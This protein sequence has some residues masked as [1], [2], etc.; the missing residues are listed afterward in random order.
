M[1]TSRSDVSFNTEAEASDAFN[2]QLIQA[3]TVYDRSPK[4]NKEGV[5]IEQRAVYLLYHEGNGEYYVDLVWREGDTPIS[6]TIIG[7]QRREF[8]PAA[9]HDLFLPLYDPLVSL[10]G[11]DRARE[12][13][14]DQARIEDH[15]RVL[16]VGCGTGTLSAGHD[17]SHGLLAHL[18]HSSHRLKDNSEERILDLM[19]RAGF[20]QARKVKGDSMFF[21]A[22]KT[23]YFEARL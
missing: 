9:G 13:L 7:H 23:S 6:S 5:L 22:L 4:V 11:G 17:G 8:L 10:L 1:Q 18:I 3:L 2:Q 12:E 15:H 14:I 21:G 19:R 16:D 20:T